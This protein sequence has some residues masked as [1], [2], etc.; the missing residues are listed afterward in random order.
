VSFKILAE[1]LY[2]DGQ[3]KAVKMQNWT[4]LLGLEQGVKVRHTSKSWIVHV[5][6]IRG[7][8]PPE[9]YGLAMNLS[10]RIA[11]ALAIKYGVILDCGRL[12]SL[13]D[14]QTCIDTSHI[15]TK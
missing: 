2:P 10:N 3:F 14:I 6:V 15:Q 12:L 11:D 7:K 1:G 8:N 9:V 4:A 5:P 13:A